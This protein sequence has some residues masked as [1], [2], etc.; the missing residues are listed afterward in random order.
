[1]LYQCT[2]PLLKCL[3]SG[4]VIAIIICIP[5]RRNI[6]NALV[7]NLAVADLILGFVLLMDAIKMVK[8]HPIAIFGTNIEIHLAITIVREAAMFGE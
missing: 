5:G 3:S 4:I 2:L 7:L 6:S 8:P 1:M